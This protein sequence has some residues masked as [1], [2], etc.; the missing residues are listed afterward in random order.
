MKHWARGY[1][2]SVRI[3]LVEDEA[4]IAAF[5]RRGLEAEGYEVVVAADGRAGMQA[6]LAGDADLVLLDLMLPEVTGEQILRRLRRECPQLPIIVKV[7]SAPSM[8]P[9]LTASSST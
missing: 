4:R 5:V 9:P 7:C 3:L 1:N 6:A 2:W 8:A